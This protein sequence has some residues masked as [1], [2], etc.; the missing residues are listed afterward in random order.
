MGNHSSVPTMPDTVLIVGDSKDMLSLQ[1]LGVS[2]DKC[3][4]GLEETLHQTK[5][6]LLGMRREFKVTLLCRERW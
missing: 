2:N 3:N 1:I 6:F 5:S 4:P